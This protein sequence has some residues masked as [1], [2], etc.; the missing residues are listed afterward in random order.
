M[1]R[2]AQTQRPYF[3][4][5]LLLCR[6]YRMPSLLTHALKQEI[7]LPVAHL[8]VLVRT[9]PQLFELPTSRNLKDGLKR[10]DERSSGLLGEGSGLPQ[11]DL[12]RHLVDGLF[13]SHR[14]PSP[15][16][17]L[18]ASEPTAVVFGLLLVGGRRNIVVTP[19]RAFRIGGIITLMLLCTLFCVVEPGVG[20]L[21]RKT[22]FSLLDAS[23][24]DVVN[25]TATLAGGY[26]ALSVKGPPLAT[27]AL[28]DDVRGMPLVDLAERHLPALVVCFDALDDLLRHGL[29]PLP[30]P[31]VRQGV[32]A[33]RQ[34]VGW[35]AAPS[36]GGRRVAVPHSYAA[37]S[38][39]VT[40]PSY[41]RRE[42][43]YR[44]RCDDSPPLDHFLRPSQGDEHLLTYLD[45]D[46][47]LQNMGVLVVMGVHRR[48]EGSWPDQVL[49]EHE[50][51]SNPLSPGHEPYAELPQPH[52]L[53]IRPLL[54]WRSVS[55]P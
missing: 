55:L 7:S 3:Y 5:T 11:E 36:S 23:G 31:F 26:G 35:G 2:G 46:L 38:C 27:A 37:S 13:C 54:V 21:L 45:A 29:L 15:S 22:S 44:G 1:N 41:S 32:P 43:K 8:L 16:V 48:S 33:R 9:A 12:F 24:E 50:G 40:R 30:P 49:D 20:E 34:V 10:H 53:T 51:F 4:S 19:G 42:A 52:S 39:R 18:R 14:L 17:F 25:N 6:I 47:S 28:K